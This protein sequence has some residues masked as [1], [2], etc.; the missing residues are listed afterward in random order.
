MRDTAQWFV[1]LLI[2][3]GAVALTWGLLVTPLTPPHQYTVD[4]EK[5]HPLGEVSDES[6]T[7]AADLPDGIADGAIDSLN[8]ESTLV[9]DTSVT[10]TLDE[11][12][13][14]PADGLLFIETDD[15]VLATTVEERSEPSFEIVL[16][17]FAGSF[18]LFLLA[19]GGY[20]EMERGRNPF[21]P[22]L[23]RISAFLRR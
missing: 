2:I 9:S 23:E 20:Q 6:L 8:S 21:P 18:L 22:A 10:V 13:D 11:A 5:A 17:K 19:F 14:V 15:A 3:G 12:Y 4:V 7:S 1:G 16:V